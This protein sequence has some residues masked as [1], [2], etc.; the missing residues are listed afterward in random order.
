MATDRR[1]AFRSSDISAL[2]TGPPHSL[3]C[4]VLHGEL[5]EALNRLERV[6]KR[7]NDARREFDRRVARRRSWW[8][9]AVAS[10]VPGI[11][12]VLAL[13]SVGEMAD[14]YEAY[15]EAYA[16]QSPLLARGYVLVPVLTLGFL[17][18]FIAV[19]A[20]WGSRPLEPL[21]TRW[22]RTMSGSLAREQA[23]LDVAT[24]VILG[25]PVF[26]E[27]VRQVE[28]IDPQLASVVRDQIRAGEP[29]A[30]RSVPTPR[31]GKRDR[32]PACEGDA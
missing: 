25:E 22:T 28:A 11:I 8:S 18:A 23:Q 21:R 3:D 24:R 19:N 17:L 32:C 30:R 31:A 14:A 16:R 6:R 13:I 20:V 7:R 1:R 27:G 15:Y 5:V 29:P 12:V 26:A 4:P 9:A 2:R 10:L